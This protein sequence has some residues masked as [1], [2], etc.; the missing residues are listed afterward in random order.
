MLTKCAQEVTNGNVGLSI[1]GSINKAMTSVPHPNPA[2]NHSHI[3]Q[4]RSYK[5]AIKSNVCM[6]CSNTV[7][8]MTNQQDKCDL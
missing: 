8:L 2:F 4:V 6:L 3:L 1:R 5:C 7:N